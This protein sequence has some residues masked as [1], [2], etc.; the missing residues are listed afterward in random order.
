MTDDGD[1]NQLKAILV[2]ADPALRDEWAGLRTPAL[3]RACARLRCRGGDD[4]DAVRG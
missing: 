1:S 3:I 4:G 2:K